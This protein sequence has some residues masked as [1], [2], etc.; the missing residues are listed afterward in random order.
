MIVITGGAGFIGSA[1]VCKCNQEGITDILI[2]DELET[3]TKWKNLIG[4]QFSDYLH[5]EDFI[6][7][8]LQ[9]DYDGKV[10]AIVHM[11]ACSDT[12]ERNVDYLMENNYRY[13]KI[14]AEWAIENKAR[15]IY[16]SS[17]ATYGNGSQ[18]FVDDYKSL[19]QL[20]PINAYGYSKHIFDLYAK[21]ENILD[22]IAGLKFFNVF[23]PNEYH[24]E[25]MRSVVCKAH[26]QILETNEL[27]LFKSYK[28][29]YPDGGQKRDFVYVKDCIDI[30][31]WLLNN[32][33]VNGLFNVGT[34]NAKTWNDL[35]NA[36][37]KAM[38]KKPNIK[39]IEMPESIRNQYQYFTE[40]SITKLRKAGY[41]K[42]ITLLDD[43]VK[44]YVT[45]YLVNESTLSA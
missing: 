2:V 8:I 45:N 30:M 7:G 13:T 25:D 6:A 9:G 27:K 10:E 15:F 3:S 36:I 43:A 29:D 37:F 35:G 44:D 26:K 12:T 23:G 32:K 28:E 11:G 19:N 34:G 22:K 33:T 39:Y 21:K 42:S 16:A 40:A 38:D 1:F 24:K 14:L 17:A 31:F 18:G 20:K 5:K 4:L 41:D